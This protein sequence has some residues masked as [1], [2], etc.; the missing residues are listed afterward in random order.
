MRCNLP[1]SMLPLACGAMLF[2]SGLAAA[3]GPRK[4]PAHQSDW[5]HKVTVTIGDLRTRIDGPKLWTLSGIDFQNTLMATEDS[6][7][8]TVVTI[9]GAGHLGTAHF[10]DV[11]GKPGE[12]EK[13]N[14]TSLRLFVDDEPV[15]SFQPTMELD[16]KSFRMER[17]SKIRAMD[18]ES[19]AQIRDGVLTESVRFHANAP[20]DLQGSYPF[21]YA[22]KHET[23]H[24]VF[25]NEDGIQQ[26]GVFR[27]E[28]KTEWHVIKDATWM[29]EF[30]SATG[31]GCVCRY[32]QNPSGEKT[33]FLLVDA[34]KIYHKV[35]AYTLIDRVVP[36]DFE[37]TYQSAVGFF[38]AA[39]KDWEQVATRKAAE[40][41]DTV[42]IP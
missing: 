10:L 39:E 9:R 29:A 20:I 23:T 26:R 17:R 12:V 7:Y 1:N 25:G 5:P 40:L 38:N 16:G 4:V 2:L 34:P 3:E 32:L 36:K 19:T 11:P 15:K 35:T 18:L 41:R 24:Y 33:W 13:E 6:A 42:R 28:G 27:K 22:W 14:V 21:M 37:A 30:D 31:K 8:G